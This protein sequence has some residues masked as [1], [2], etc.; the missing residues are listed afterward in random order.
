MEF[1]FDDYFTISYYEN[2]DEYFPLKHFEKPY[3]LVIP[4]EF[5]QS[6]FLL[7]ERDALHKMNFIMDELLEILT[8]SN[9]KLVFDFL[10]YQLQEYTKKNRDGLI[11]LVFIEELIKELEPVKESRKKTIID[12][13]EEKRK[14]LSQQ[15]AKD[16]GAEVPTL[17]KIEWKGSPALFGYLFTELIDKGYIEYEKHGTE[18]S[19][20]GTAKL[21]FNHFN[22]YNKK[23]ELTTL[24]NLEK[25]FNPASAKQTLSDTKRAKFTIPNLS[26]LA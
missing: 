7:S 18:R 17:K 13:I 25:E 24:Q 23:G 3:D 11:F 19:Y 9:P 1:D 26:D 8:G 12:W 6:N 14:E 5:Q 15:T 16:R 4:N 22:V 10:T 20:Q 21:F 2:E